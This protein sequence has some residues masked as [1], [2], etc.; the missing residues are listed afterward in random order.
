MPSFANN[1]VTETRVLYRISKNRIAR[2]PLTF[3]E[4]MVLK[5]LE[6]TAEKALAQ[7]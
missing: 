7:Y 3:S 1:S 5:N 2:Q 6:D 4:K